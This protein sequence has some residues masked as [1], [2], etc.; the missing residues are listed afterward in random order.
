[1]QT[2]FDMLAVTLEN[3][4][5]DFSVK[6]VAEGFSVN[7]PGVSKPL[8]GEYDML[9][10]DCGSE[11][12]VDWKTSSSKWALDKAH[13]DLQAT[14]F[15]YARNKQTGKS[16]LFRFDVVTKTKTPSLESHYTERREQDFQRFELLAQKIEAAVKQEMFYPNETCFSCSDCQYK[17]KCQLWH[18]RRW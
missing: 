2:G 5:D 18:L 10:D 8:I 12:I 16:P 9:V 17:C 1:M 15:C 6:S 4:Q 13:R 3:W 14:V 7:I 11:S